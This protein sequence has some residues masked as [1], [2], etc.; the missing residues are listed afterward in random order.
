[1]IGTLLY[2]S[3]LLYAFSCIA[4]Q[5]QHC[6][7]HIPVCVVFI[8]DKIVYTIL[9]VELIKIEIDPIISI[10]MED[11]RVI[12]LL[13]YHPTNYMYTVYTFDTQENKYHIP[14]PHTT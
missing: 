10:Y 9:N 12:S 13:V 5:P 4:N 11:A 14:R 6:L 7:R 1:M 2:N 8:E 3:W